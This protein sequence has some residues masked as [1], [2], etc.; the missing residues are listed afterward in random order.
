MHLGDAPCLFRIISTRPTTTRG[1]IGFRDREQDGDRMSTGQDVEAWLERL[2]EVRLPLDHQLTQSHV[3]AAGQPPIPE[4]GPYAEAGTLISHFEAIKTIELLAE[5]KYMN[6][7]SELDS[8]P[9]QGDALT[10]KANFW[11]SV[12]LWAASLK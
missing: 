11:R 3:D 12:Q 2:E 6:T 4:A 7:F 5:N 8:N 10:A 1:T 9:G